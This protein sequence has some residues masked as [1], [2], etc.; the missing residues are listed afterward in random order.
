MGERGWG[1]VTPAAL[2][3]GQ[4]LGQYCGELINMEEAMHRVRQV[5]ARSKKYY[6]LEYDASAGEVIDAGMRGNKLRFVNHS[7]DPNCY[8]EKWLLSGSEEDR[9]AEYQLGLFALRDIEAG[10]ELTYNYGWSAFQPPRLDKNGERVS[11]ERCLCGSP[12]C[13]GWLARMPKKRA[14]ARPAKTI[15]KKVVT[16]PKIPPPSAAHI[17]AREARARRR[18]ARLTLEEPMPEASP[19]V[20]HSQ[21]KRRAPCMVPELVVKPGSTQTDSSS[22]QQDVLKKPVRLSPLLSETA[23]SETPSLG[24]SESPLTPLDVSSPE[25]EQPLTPFV[26]VFEPQSPINSFCEYDGPLFDA[27][28]SPEVEIVL[29]A[30]PLGEP[31]E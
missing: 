8:F 5:Y 18:S 2:Y 23:P 19:V 22:P 21:R 7:C 26:L 12:N 16:A 9:N 17:Q 31:E 30:S 27:S 13:T 29:P 15:E 14:L 28:D 11:G 10:E 1:L 4:Y 25:S 20:R 6:F 3:K 24:S